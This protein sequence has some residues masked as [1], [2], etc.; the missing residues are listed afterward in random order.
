MYMYILGAATEFRVTLLKEKDSVA[1][2][3]ISE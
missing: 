3:F 2:W 1:C